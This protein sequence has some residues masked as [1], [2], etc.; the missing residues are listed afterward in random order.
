M[1][2]DWKALELGFPWEDPAAS[3]DWKESLPDP[4]CAQDRPAT[5]EAA[6]SKLREISCA[7]TGCALAKRAQSNEC[8]TEGSNSNQ[9]T[10]EKR[11]VIRVE[12]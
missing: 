9:R 6:E 2:W 3:G 12:E 11:S 10:R 1:G 5:R 7:A 4:D 8:E